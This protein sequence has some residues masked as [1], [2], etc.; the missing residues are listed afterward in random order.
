M[1]WHRDGH[2]AASTRTGNLAMTSHDEDILHWKAEGQT[3]GPEK[4][5]RVG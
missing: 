5:G 2:H 4:N 1:A 3:V